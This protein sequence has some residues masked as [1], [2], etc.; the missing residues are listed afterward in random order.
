MQ[1]KAYAPVVVAILN[2]SLF[3]WWFIIL[4]ECRHSNL[5]EI[6]NFPVKPE[7]IPGNTKQKLAELLKTLMNDLQRHTQRKEYMYKATGKVIYD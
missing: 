7:K 2:N 3:C 6:E 5:R 4:S 1:T